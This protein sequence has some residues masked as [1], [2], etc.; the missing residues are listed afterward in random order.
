MDWKDWRSLNYFGKSPFGLGGN[1]S[2]VIRSESFVDNPE[3][4]SKRVWFDTAINGEVLRDQDG[5]LKG[6]GGEILHPSQWC[7]DE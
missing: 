2:E 5:T 7:F 3:G 1:T 6:K 4:Q